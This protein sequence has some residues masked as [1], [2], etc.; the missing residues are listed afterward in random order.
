[1]RPLILLLGCAII[2]LSILLAFIGV[3]SLLF[4][5]TGFLVI[6]NAVLWFIG[7]VIIAIVGAV[8]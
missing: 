8:V 4:T 2:A 5:P 3:I 7:G 6:G 1:M